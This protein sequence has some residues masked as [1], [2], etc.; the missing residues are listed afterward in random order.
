MRQ[1]FQL[2]PRLHPE[3][4]S[5]ACNPEHMISQALNVLPR[6]PNRWAAESVSVSL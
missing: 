1:E 6:V 3:A 2:S 5:E 4:S